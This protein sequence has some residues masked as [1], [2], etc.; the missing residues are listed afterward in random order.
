MVAAIDRRRTDVLVARDAEPLRV[1]VGRELA[2]KAGAVLMLAV[3]L[4]IVDVVVLIV[5]LDPLALPERGDDVLGLRASG[6]GLNQ[7]TRLGKAADAQQHTSVELRNWRQPWSIAD[8]R[9]EIGALSQGQTRHVSQRRYRSSSSSSGRGA[10][11][12]LSPSR[13]WCW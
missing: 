2:A 11:D 4:D 10:T 1:E 6:G 13:S 8:S 9:A 7:C 12:D 5:A 3:V